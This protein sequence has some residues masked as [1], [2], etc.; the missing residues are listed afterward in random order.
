MVLFAENSTLCKGSFKT[1]SKQVVK[2]QKAHGV[3]PHRIQV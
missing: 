3:D 2:R 1:F